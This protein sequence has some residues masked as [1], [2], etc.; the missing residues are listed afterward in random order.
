LNTKVKPFDDLNVRKAVFAG[1]DRKAMNLAFGG[2]TVGKI[3]TH[4]IPPGV[5]G[6]EEAGGFEGPDLDFL[7]TPEGDPELAAEYMK[8]AGFASGKYEGP[9]LLMVADNSTNQKSAATAL[10][11]SME[12]LGFEIRLRPVTRDTMYS[13]YCGV[14]KSKTPICPSTGWLKDFADPQTMLGP[15]FDGDV[16]LPSNNV[17]WPQLD[18]PEINEAMD[19]AELIVGD[20]ERA[21]AWADIDKMVME[22]AA[23]LTW[24]WDKPYLVRSEN[25]N[26]VLNK[27]NAAWD[28][29]S[30]SLK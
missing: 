6:F 21:K 1:M 26:P 24:Q 9:P 2:E 3:A 30:I 28:L 10:L 22:Q 14:P 23:A 16:I 8:K 5:A 11:N 29:S 25:V 12:K 7:K 20:E 15:T 4:I 17:N 19:K 13:K 18:V 27:A